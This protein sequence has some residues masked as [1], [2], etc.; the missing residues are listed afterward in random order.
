MAISLKGDM[1]HFKGGS[2]F[3]EERVA[4]KF[5]KESDNKTSNYC[6]GWSISMRTLWITGTFLGSKVLIKTWK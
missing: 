2:R 6:I 5:E 4:N 3:E 1:Q